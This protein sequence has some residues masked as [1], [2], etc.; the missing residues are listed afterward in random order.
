MSQIYESKSVGE[1]TNIDPDNVSLPE[2]IMGANALVCD[3]CHMS[4]TAT[5]RKI[6]VRW[7]RG[8]PENQDGPFSCVCLLRAAKKL[9]RIHRLVAWAKKYARIEKQ[10]HSHRGMPEYQE[11]HQ[12]LPEGQCD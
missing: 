3:R 5:W 9:E 2:S 10:R 8:L 4:E 12:V 7:A 1:S 6:L 11:I